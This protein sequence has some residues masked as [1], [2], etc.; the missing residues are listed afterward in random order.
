[1]T[2]YAIGLGSN[3]GDRLANLRAGIGG[4]ASIGDV[5]DVSP[6]Y[7]TEPVGGPD[8]GPYLN[9]VA[10]V[11]TD[12]DP[13]PLLAA[14]HRVETG[15][16]RER[17]TRWGARTLDLD[18]VSTDGPPVDRS[19]L[20]IPHPRA[21]QREF[22][23]RPLVD[24]WPE[25]TVA[26]GENALTALAVCKRQGVER[27]LAGWERDDY[28]WIGRALVAAQLV[29]FA[30]IAVAMALDGSVPEPPVGLGVV[31]GGALALLGMGLAVASARSLGSGLTPVPDPTDDGVLIDTGP[32]ALARH[33]IYGGVLLFLLGAA[34]AL[35]SI[36]AVV[37]SLGLAG[38]FYLKSRYEE[39]L[40]R[41][42]YPG[43]RDYMESVRSR[44]IPFVI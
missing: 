14:L 18:I 40:L 15:Q 25:A 23:L 26:S 24:V 32:Y 38:F 22:V 5:I 28:R 41:L 43:Y 37:L 6:V 12:L 30:F 36:V 33:P 11:E 31:L 17:G 3:L 20:V 16:G 19:D 42:R 8:Q 39:R 21:Q 9:A 29:W 34:L 44:F 4:L 35:D 10:V 13:E 27:L 1:M 7:E 2:R